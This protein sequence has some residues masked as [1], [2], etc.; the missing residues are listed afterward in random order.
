MSQGRVRHPAGRGTRCSTREGK[1]TWRGR[2]A[3]TR[4]AAGSAR[5]SDAPMSSL[6]S[7]SC[8]SRPVTGHDARAASRCVPAPTPACLHASACTCARTCARACACACA[9]SDAGTPTHQFT[10]THAS[11]NHER[12]QTATNLALVVSVLGKV[13]GKGGLDAVFSDPQEKG[14]G[15]GVYPDVYRVLEHLLRVC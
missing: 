5:P 13:R 6:S 7:L 8:R 9:R 11:D 15:L 4:R 12:T 2:R 1:E 10:R 3:N 14:F